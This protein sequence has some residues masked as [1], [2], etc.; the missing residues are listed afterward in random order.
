MYY[1]FF[2]HHSE[3]TETPMMPVNVTLNEDVVFRCRHTNA[4][5]YAWY[6]NGSAIGNN[7]PADITPSFNTLTIIALPRNNNTVIQC[8]AIIHNG[9]LLEEGSP[10]VILI[11]PGQTL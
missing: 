9:T 8:V 10:P 1:Y 7:P 11:I 3:F 5:T 6:I 4:L 2:Y